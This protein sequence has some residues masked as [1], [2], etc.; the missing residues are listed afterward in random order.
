MDLVISFKDTSTIKVINDV[1]SFWFDYGVLNIVLENGTLRVYPDRHIFY[2]E[3]V[4][5]YK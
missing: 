3:V 4:E 5:Y 2:V 1:K